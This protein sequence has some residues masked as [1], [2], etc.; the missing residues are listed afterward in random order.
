MEATLSIVNF[1]TGGPGGK[2]GLITSP[3]SLEACLRL[4]CD[5]KELLPIPFKAFGKSTDKKKVVTPEEQQIRYDHYE[6]RRK[7]KIAAIKER[8]EAIM[9]DPASFQSQKLVSQERW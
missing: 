2:P 3:R 6:G 5:P 4:G 9:R 1:E 7:E 8:R